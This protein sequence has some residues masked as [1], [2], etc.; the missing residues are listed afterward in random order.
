MFIQNVVGRLFGGLERR[1]PATR[2]FTAIVAYTLPMTE[3]L[4]KA[5]SEVK[6]LSEVDQDAIAQLIL[7]ELEDERRWDAAFTKSP[8]L[9]EQ[10]L[11][12]AET[13]DRAGLTR[14]CKPDES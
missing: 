9:L 4:E 11:A 10:L 3:L 12:E 6:R 2:R 1:H 8:E 5:I 14:E 7:E 13:E